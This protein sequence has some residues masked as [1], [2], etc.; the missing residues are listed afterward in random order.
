[1][2]EDDVTTSPTKPPHGLMC[3]LVVFQPRNVVAATLEATATT[4]NAAVYNDGASL[5][6]HHGASL[7]SHHETQCVSEL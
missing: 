4:M 1:M 7:G 5:G 2:L 3:L 6:N